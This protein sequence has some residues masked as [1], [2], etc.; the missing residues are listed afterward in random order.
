MSFATLLWAAFCFT[1]GFG[2]FIIMVPLIAS[3]FTKKNK[4]KKAAEANRHAQAQNA[5]PST[6]QPML[7]P[8]LMEPGTRV[9]ET[10]PEAQ[11]SAYRP[12]FKPKYEVQGSKHTAIRKPAVQR[13]NW[14][15]HWQ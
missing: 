13:I 15:A 12:V 5:G 7:Q 3:I 14:N 11:P 9:Q 2:I 1:V 8:P 4:L 6:M 10:I